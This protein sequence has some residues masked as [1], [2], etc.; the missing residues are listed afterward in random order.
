MTKQGRIVWTKAVPS[1]ISGHKRSAASRPRRRR[2]FKPSSPARRAIRRSLARLQT[3]RGFSAAASVRLQTEFA[4]SPQEPTLSREAPDDP[5]LLGRGVGASSNRVRPLA[6]GSDALSRG[7]GRF[8][9]S[10]PRRRRVF[11]PSSPARRRIRRSRAR[12]RTVRGFLAAASVRLRTEASARSLYDLR[13]SRGVTRFRG[14]RLAAP[15]DA[16]REAGR[17]SPSLQ[18]RRRRVS[19]PRSHARRADR[20][21]L[22]RL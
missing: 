13:H 10:R 5:R 19:G 11:K 16:P 20:R 15:I 1:S 2:V 8:A 7:S 22:A 12:L 17:R 21:S 9:A 3:I 14:R 4:R 18:P 6:A